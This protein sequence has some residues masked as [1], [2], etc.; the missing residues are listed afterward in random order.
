MSRILPKPP[1]FSFVPSQS[2]CRCTTFWRGTG[3]DFGMDDEAIHAAQRIRFTPA[4][5]DGKPVDFPARIRIEFRLVKVENP[6]E[7][8][9]LS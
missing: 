3:L 7:L 2:I 9:P 8:P 1:E 6:S 5:L 4:M